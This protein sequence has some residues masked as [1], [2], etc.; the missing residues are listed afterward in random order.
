MTAT[1][2]PETFIE[3]FVHTD[4]QRQ[5]WKKGYRERKIGTCNGASKMVHTNSGDSM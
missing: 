4:T 3:M 2:A 1:T 5:T